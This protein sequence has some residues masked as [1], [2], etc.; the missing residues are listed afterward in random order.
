M[1]EPRNPTRN[2]EAALALAQTGSHC[3][4]RAGQTERESG[5]SGQAGIPEE[6]QPLWGFI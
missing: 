4:P 6:S 2:G 3:C 5:H 1:E